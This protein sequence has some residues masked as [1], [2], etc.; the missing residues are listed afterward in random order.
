[1]NDPKTDVEIAVGNLVKE[2][3]EPLTEIIAKIKASDERSELHGA[4]HSM[5]HP[6]Q[7][8]LKAAQESQR[9]L[10]KAIV[11]P[12]LLA[13]LRLV[14]DLVAKWRGDPMWKEIE[15][16]LVNQEVFMHT[17]ST[18]L[19]AEHLRREG[20]EVRLVGKLLVCTE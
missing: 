12:W 20:H 17:I 10:P 9:I 2:S 5:R 7:V 4:P 18:L 6:L 8:L 14:L 3:G 15:P 11:K 19:V 16:S 13:E 1:L